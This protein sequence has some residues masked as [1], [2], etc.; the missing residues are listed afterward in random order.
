MYTK[1]LF[2]AMLLSVYE[3]KFPHDNSAYKTVSEA[4]YIIDD[5]CHNFRRIISEALGAAKMCIEGYEDFQNNKQGKREKLRLDI[6]NFEGLFEYGTKEVI[7]LQ[8][9]GTG[10]RGFAIKQLRFSEVVNYVVNYDLKEWEKIKIC[11]LCGKAFIAKRKQERYCSIP[12]LNDIPC[13]D[14]SSETRR[15]FNLEYAIF[16][17]ARNIHNHRKNKYGKRDGDAT[18]GEW[19]RFADEQRTLL[20]ESKITIDAYENRIAEGYT[21]DLEDK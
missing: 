1:D 19:Y 15:K 18:Y 16:D 6:S 10:G 21:L 5:Y 13:R 2:L 4:V 9:P 17:R 12:G 11:E 20:H 3:D 7:E 8:P 14:L